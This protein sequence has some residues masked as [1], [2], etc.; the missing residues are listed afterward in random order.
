MTDQPRPEADP[1]ADT[2]VSPTPL[3]AEPLMPPAATTQSA[4]AT[5]PPKPAEAPATDDTI[6]PMTPVAT[7]PIGPGGPDA[8]APPKRSRA[9]WVAALAIVGLVIAGSA[10]L[11]LALTGAAPASTVIGYVPSDSVVYGE[12]RLD[13]PGDQQQEVGEFLSHFP[14]FADQAALGTKLDEVLDRLVSDATDGDQTYTA[15]V[16]PWFGG[17]LGFAVGALPT[18]A[19]LDDPAS[20]AG[21]GHG[22]VLLSVKDG[23]LAQSWFD[24]MASETGTSGTTEDYQGVQL[25]VFSEPDMPGVEAAYGIIDG[26]VLVAGDVASVKAAIDTGGNGGLADDPT[27]AAAANATTTDHVGFVFVDIKALVS[28]AMSMVDDGGAAPLGSDTLV[29]LVPDWAAFAIRVEGDAIVMDGALPHNDELPGPD[30]N[31][32]N[33]VAD[34]APPTTVVLAAVN[35][36]GATLNELIDLLRADPNLAEA[37]S[38]ID[39]AAGILGGLESLVGWMGD[40]GIVVSQDGSVLEG[41]IV[42]IPADAD[43][44]SQ[45]LSTLRSLIALAGSSEGLSVR[46]EDYNGTT[47]TIID[48]GT[49]Q[50]LAGMAGQLGG[51]EFPID[52]STG[53]ASDDRVEIAFAA[54]DQVV[55]I[56]SG[57]DFVKSVLDAGAG[58]SLAD[59]A[60]YAGLVE[61]V[62]TEHT[63]VT[64]VDIAA[65]RGLLEGMMSDMSAAERA[66]YDESVKPFL[67]PLDALVSATSLGG[68][69]DT[70]RT[71]ITVR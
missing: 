8:A 70:Q 50:D 19:N 16:A 23:A 37:F 56:G 18:D 61:R 22:L 33:G 63:G 14:G 25:T 52:P 13:L 24:D 30:T 27:F 9:R 67:E 28:G 45:L 46:D 31:H 4:P 68:E 3:T 55:V 21:G 32:A 43:G 6:E 71:I 66:E 44:A 41:G 10:A 60:R 40:T 47:I 39:Q 11:A 57:P 26:K 69:I 35:D 17:E 58:T 65:I 51:G 48:L 62:G 29:G 59:E 64:F 2:T 42:S 12:V 36:Y 20:V 1:H 7:T 5:T 53:P 38:G 34:W 49:A 15:D 54:T